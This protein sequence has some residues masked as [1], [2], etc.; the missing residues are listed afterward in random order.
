MKKSPVKKILALALAVLFLLPLLPAPATAESPNIL[1]V[2]LLSDIHYFREDMAGGYGE[3]FMQGNAVGHPIEQTP[4]LL[5][6][7]LAAIAERADDLDYLL[8]SG[9]L[10]RYGEYDGH[11]ELAEILKQF[12]TD[13]GIDIAVVPGNHD[14]DSGAA[15]FANGVKE[16]ARKTTEEDFL[17]FYEDLGYDLA[18]ERFNPT[19]EDKAGMLSYAADIG[20]GYR[21]IAIDTFRRK[22]TPELQ[23]WIIGQCEEAVAA[24][25]TVVGMGHHNLNEQLNGQLR[26]MQNQGIE[27]MREISES[28]ADAGMHF[29]FSGHLHMSEISPWYS[30]S[31]EVLYDIIVPGL[32]TFPGDY[33]VVT[34]SS[35]NGRIEADV[36]SYAPDEVLEITANGITYPRPYRPTA[37]ELTFGYNGNGLNGFAK[38]NLRRTLGE[39]LEKLRDSGGITAMVKNQVDLGPVNA[40]FEYL[41]ERLINDP[42]KIIGVLNDLLDDALA[43]PVS[44]LPCN[45]FLDLGFGDATKPGT[46][47]DM[48]TAAIV[49]MFWKNHD[50]Q[51]DPFMMDVL[52][53]LQNGELL[54]QLLNYALPK[55]FD[56]LGADLI[57][58]I[59]DCVPVNSALAK[60][61]NSIGSPLITMPLLA[62]IPGTRD[63]IN[64][65]LYELASKI[66]TSQSPT[67]SGNGIVVYDP[68][69][70]Q[71]PAGPRTFRLPFDLSFTVSGDQKS[72]EIVWYT[73]ASLTSPGLKLTDSM[74]VPAAEAE[75]ALTTE[76]ADVTVETIDLAIMQ[77]MGYT[78]RAAKHTAKI[79]NLTPGKSYRFSAGDTE[80][81]WW[82]EPQNLTAAKENQIVTFFTRL[83]EWIRGF[84]R[85]LGISWKN[86]SSGF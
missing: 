32:F 81:E 59:S 9:D 85:M 75:I 28:F 51:D 86:Q 35:L 60:A 31:G 1:R 67:G 15:T 74:G 39:Q 65:S 77:L 34:F 26:I 54:D 2:A 25:K 21:L 3:V 29:Y 6:S 23:A 68:N 22:I 37:L 30:D 33:R 57:P 56:V 84:L 61:L 13:T 50:P 45:R 7:A 16:S 27:N 58:L 24:G 10:T 19:G 76:F 40:L 14:I 46:V 69:N 83:W 52:G 5:R 79:T 38:E 20:D 78:I 53:R 48:A 82:S 49:Y 66:I 43:L 8:I 73:K 63:T 70:L 44:K 64:N 17:A 4:G 11:A 18:F 36:R 41:D 12:E 80:F 55:I 62:L 72:A 47:S 42:D 71:T